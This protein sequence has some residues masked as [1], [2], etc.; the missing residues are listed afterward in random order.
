MLIGEVL[1]WGSFHFGSV[2]YKFNGLFRRN[3]YCLLYILN[4]TFE[5]FNKL[6]QNNVRPECVAPLLQQ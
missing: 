3:K 1:L 4:E 6:M 5:R 2:F